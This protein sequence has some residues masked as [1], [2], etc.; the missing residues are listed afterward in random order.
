M[1]ERGTI[2]FWNDEKGFG[3]INPLH[4]GERVFL[5]IRS[6]STHQG[7]PVVGDIVRFDVAKDDQGRLRA[8][9]VRFVV[10]DHPVVYS[11]ISTGGVIA[12]LVALAFF[13]VLAVLV[14]LNELP[15]GA[16][17]YFVAAAVLG[18]V[19]FWS[20]KR[21]AEAREWRISEATLIMISVFG[22]WPGAI[23][24]QQF[25]RHKYRKVSFMA[26]FWLCVLLNC[27]AVALVVVAF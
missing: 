24:G 3:F 23:L 20:D 5:H 22:G 15:A 10:G 2:S 14:F 26:P 8:E 18:L 12:I 6:F 21:R 1:E 13:G 7:R 9:N 27:G 19:A 4:G 16:L 11:P 25:F 17:V